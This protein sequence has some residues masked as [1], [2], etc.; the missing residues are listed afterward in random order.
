MVSSA[1]LNSRFDQLF[2]ELYSRVGQIS[3]DLQTTNENLQRTN[4][5]LEELR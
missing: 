3:T 2:V 1:E 5:N 4:E